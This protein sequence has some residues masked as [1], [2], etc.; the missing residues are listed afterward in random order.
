MNNNFRGRIAGTIVAFFGWLAAI[1]MYLAFFASGLDFWQKLA[2]FVASG[3]ILI[4]ITAVMWIM[5]VMK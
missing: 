4:A 3:S 1:L 2:V 5:W